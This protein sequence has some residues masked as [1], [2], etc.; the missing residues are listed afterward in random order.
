[1]GKQAGRPPM[2][3]SKSFKVHVRMDAATRERL[4][5]CAEALQTSCSDVI[6]RGIDKLFEELPRE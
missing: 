4:E 3:N 6:R 2:E 5:A 1:M